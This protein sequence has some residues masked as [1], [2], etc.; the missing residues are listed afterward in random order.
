MTE[1][2]KEW[3]G[4][5]VEEV[6]RKQLSLEEEKMVDAEAATL[7]VDFDHTRPTITIERHPSN[8][9]SLPGWFDNIP[10]PIILP[11]FYF[12]FKNMETRILNS[13]DGLGEEVDTP[14]IVEDKK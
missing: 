7:N 6:Q 12:D 13:W 3:M 5:Q 9:G 2:S 10:L 14:I 11:Q 1:A 4:K 8:D